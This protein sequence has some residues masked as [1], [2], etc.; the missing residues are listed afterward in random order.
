M[1]SVG[2]FAAAQENHS[3]STLM[4][5]LTFIVT[6]TL[7]LN[8]LLSLSLSLSQTHTHTHAHVY[9]LSLSLSP[10]SATLS[11]ILQVSVSLPSLYFIVFDAHSLSSMHSTHSIDGTLTTQTHS[12][13]SCIFLYHPHKP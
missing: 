4:K 13:F 9:P 6:C 8:L 10:L 1:F 12:L 7:T 5:F 3:S 2:C 11:I